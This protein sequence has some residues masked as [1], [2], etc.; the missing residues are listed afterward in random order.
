MI[1]T[2]D[3]FIKDWGVIIQLAFLRIFLKILSLVNS[4]DIQIFFPSVFFFTLY[5]ISSALLELV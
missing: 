3:F 4:L 5:T 2:I 1:S